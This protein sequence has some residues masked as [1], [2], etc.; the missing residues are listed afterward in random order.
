MT[1][2]TLTTGKSPLISITHLRKEAAAAIDRLIAF[3]DETESDPDLEPDLDLED[4]ADDEPS[5]GWNAGSEYQRQEG[6]RFYINADGGQD[7]E[8]E[9][10]GREPE[11]DS[12]PDVDSEPSLGWT[13][14]P[15]QA[16]AAWQANHLG[17][18]DLEE[19]VGAVRKK[20]PASKTGGKVCRWCEVLAGS[21]NT[22]LLAMT[23]TVCALSFNQVSLT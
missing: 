20:R 1:T 5:L 9:H 17:T 10:C 21:I 12:E 23:S 11:D 22:R 7:L 19:G 16:S 6:R 13:D 18:V 8:D 3:L 4:G 14:N 15:N 2:A